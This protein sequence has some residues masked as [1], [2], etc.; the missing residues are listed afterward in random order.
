MSK[1]SFKK[2]FQQKYKGRGNS[3]IKV[4]QSSE[5]FND[6]QN[7]LQEIGEEASEFLSLINRENFAWLR[8]SKVEGDA[9]NPLCTFEV[10]YKGSKI[11]HPDCTISFDANVAQD[12]P[13]LGNTPHKLQLEIDPSKRVVN[14][15]SQT[16]KTKKEKKCEDAEEAKQTISII[17][18]ATLSKPT[19]QELKEWH[20]WLKVN[21]M[22]E[23]HAV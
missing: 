3:W 17:R 2:E 13:L 18:E 23:E 4:P 21:N 19:S 6:I 10:R 9:D 11:D 14:N 8:F 15:S 7:L 1:N 5:C 12:L 20:D 16:I 22:Y